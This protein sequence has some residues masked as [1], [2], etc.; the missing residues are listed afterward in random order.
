MKEAL[1]AMDLSASLYFRSLWATFAE[2][3]GGRE[4]ERERER[5][6]DGGRESTLKK[7]SREVRRK[8]EW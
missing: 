2:E 1:R 7:L 5:E 3:E 4:S 6:G 8:I